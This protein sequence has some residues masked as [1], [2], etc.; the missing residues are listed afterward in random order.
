MKI[1]FIVSGV[2]CVL[3]AVFIFFA[4]TNSLV[5][6]KHETIEQEYSE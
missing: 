4:W 1:I 6:K 3:V 2:L 5:A